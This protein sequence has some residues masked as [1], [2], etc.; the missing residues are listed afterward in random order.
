VPVLESSSDAVPD[1]SP[2]PRLL[3]TTPEPPARV[4]RMRLAPA[5]SLDALDT[6][7]GLAAKYDLVLFDARSRRVH[8]PLEEMAAHASATF[9][10][11]G[12]IQAAVAGGIGGV[13][14]V[15]GWFLG[16]PLLSG[17]LLLLG[18]F[19]VAMAVYTFV[20]EARKSVKGGRTRGGD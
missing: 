4:V 1:A 3:A 6:I 5:T 10:P 14:A 15:V 12:A 9:W 7:F 16:L 11:G 20:H 19:M 13:I 8:I 18:G 17:I 2:A